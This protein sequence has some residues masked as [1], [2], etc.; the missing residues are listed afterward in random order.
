MILFCLFLVGG[1]LLDLA[2]IHVPDGIDKIYHFIGFAL[3][4][5]LAISIF[6]SFFGKKWINSYFIFLL[7]SGGILGGVSEYLQ[8]LTAVRGCCVEDWLANLAGIT[9]VVI[10]AYIFYSKEEKTIELTQGRFDFKDIP[11]I[12]Y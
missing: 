3:I 1:I 2:P 10:L 12:Y 6:V 9:L 8:K 7:I 5:V 4:T 11:I